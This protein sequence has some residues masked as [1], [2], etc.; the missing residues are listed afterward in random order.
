ME[1]QTVTLKLPPN[2]LSRAS[3]IAQAQDVTIG[4]LVRDL[5]RKEVNRQLNAKT[6]NRADERLVA[7]LQA[8]LATQM[9]L[10]SGW[11]DLAHRL[12]GEGY[13]L[14]PAGGGLTMHRRPCGTR[15]CKASE[16]GFPYR[17]L[18][19]RFCGGMPGHPH[20][21]L[22]LVFGAP[23]PRQPA[24]PLEGDAEFEVIDFDA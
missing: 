5:L 23:P 10:A 21:A 1:H 8:L 15:L 19:K 9:A 17:T 22:D 12:A 13:E 2:L 24:L 16:L 4:H 7:A 20:G 3:T 14:R 18:V 11:E 6:P